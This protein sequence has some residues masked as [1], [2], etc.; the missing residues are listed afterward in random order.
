MKVNLPATKFALAVNKLHYR[1][2]SLL[3]I[4]LRCCDAAMLR[5]SLFVL[6][7]SLPF[8][9]VSFFCFPFKKDCRKECFLQ[10]KIC[11]W[12]YHVRLCPSLSVTLNKFEHIDSF[13]WSLVR[14]TCILLPYHQYCQHCSNISEIVLTLAP[15]S[16][17]RIVKLC[18]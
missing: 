12:Y 16:Q 11:F 4:T 13:S 14:T 17:C 2:D 6:I 15:L 10:G 3:Q 9:L 7:F 18:V 1:W 8:L 5:F